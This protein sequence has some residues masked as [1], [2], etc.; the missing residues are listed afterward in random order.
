MKRILVLGII[1]L[2]IGMSISSSTGLP[3]QQPDFEIVDVEIKYKSNLP[4]FLIS[5]ENKGL[6]VH[7]TG[8]CK[9]TFKLLFLNKTIFYD[10]EDWGSVKPHRLNEIKV[11]TSDLRI[12]K[13]P[14]I[15]IGRIFFEVNPNRIVNES[16]EKNNAV[17]TYIYLHYF[18]YGEENMITKVIIGKLRPQS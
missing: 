1:L 6:C 17:W 5:I 8:E 10:Y 15:F 2:F 7:W 12:G 18:G 9:I 13:L 14:R 11:L 3:I 4:R 16:N